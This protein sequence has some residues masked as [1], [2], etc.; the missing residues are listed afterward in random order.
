MIFPKMDTSLFELEEQ[1]PKQDNDLHLLAASLM[2]AVIGA[3]GDT[4][5]LELAQMVDIL[6]SRYSLST[7]ETS[8]L[9]RSARKATADD[10]AV[11][12]L[13]QKIC[14]YLGSKEREQL[15]NDFWSLAIADSEIR[16]DERL[17]IDRIANNLQ[18]DSDDITRARYQAEQRLELNIS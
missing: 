1:T 12:D 10:E 5:Q 16:T 2:F 8:D 3:D 7:E 13:A 11:E 15:L 4:D 9:I 6:R 18:L 14:K 17:V